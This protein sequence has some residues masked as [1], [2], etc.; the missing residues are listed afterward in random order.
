MSDN[1]SLFINLLSS[2]CMISSV[3]TSDIMTSPEAFRLSSQRRM[4]TSIE[5]FPLEVP[6]KNYPATRVISAHQGQLNYAQL[7][8]FV[9]IEHIV[10]VLKSGDYICGAI[11]EVYCIS[12]R[13]NSVIVS[14]LYKAEIE[15]ARQHQVE[16]CQTL[17]MLASNV[18]IGQVRRLRT[19]L[20]YIPLQR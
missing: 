15:Y 4:F 18:L 20:N 9:Q 2:G 16:V 3:S 19:K 5:E 13:T 10:L 17:S 14:T 6:R 12:L 1:I 8:Y 11:Y 7:I